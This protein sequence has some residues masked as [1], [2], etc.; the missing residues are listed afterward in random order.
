MP[1]LASSSRMTVAEFLEWPGEGRHTRYQLVDGEIRA[2][3]PAGVRHGRIQANI[4]RLLG[5]HLDDSRCQ[6]VVEPGVVP[7]VRS[8]T[9]LRVPDI[10][11]TC[12]PDE[13]AQQ[14]LL[15]PVL[16]I[17]V[18]S[19]SNESETRENVWSYT[20]IPGLR[21][22]LL[23]HSTRVAAELLERQTDGEW[24]SG[25][26][27]LGPDDTLCLASIDFQCPLGALYRGT[28]LLDRVS[29]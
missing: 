16:L 5:N 17:E 15:N 20:T 23:I 11:I 25:A 6:V 26:R 7:R 4:V 22:I 12:E 10:G 8:E 24:P 21:E 14:T 27:L 3:A 19:P 29:T 18:L 9:N 1:K 28:R 13:P 2:M